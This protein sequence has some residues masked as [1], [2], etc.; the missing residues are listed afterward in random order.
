MSGKY[1]HS[2][3]LPSYRALEAY[4]IQVKQSHI[5]DICVSLCMPCR[6]IILFKLPLNC[7]S[8]LLFALNKN[9]YSTYSVD[10][11]SMWKNRAAR[12]KGGKSDVRSMGTLYVIVYQLL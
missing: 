1:A 12:K 9:S 7:L 4:D 6:S 5:P 10:E 11:S 8:L 3:K 2:G